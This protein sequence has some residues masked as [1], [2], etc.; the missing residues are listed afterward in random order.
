MTA[1]TETGHPGLNSWWNMMMMMKYES[2]CHSVRFQV[3]TAESMKFRVFWVMSAWW[4]SQYAPLK[5]RS[6]S[7]WLH[8]ATSQKTLNLKCHSVEGVTLEVNSEVRSCT[9]EPR[10]QDV[11]G[12]GIKGPCS[13]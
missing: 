12:S 7:T 8:G 11:W 5:R 3:H 9:Q 4:W 10:R 1:E 6:T 2:M 13:F